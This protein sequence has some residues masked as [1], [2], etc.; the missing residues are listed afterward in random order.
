M[1]S[2]E[3]R[4]R[5]VTIGASQTM[6]A[7]F[8]FLTA[9]V[10]TVVLVPLVGQFAR[11][12]G[13]TSQPSSNR[14]GRRSV[15][16]IGGVAMV[17]PLLFAA[18]LGGGFVA[19]RPVLIAS[20]L[21]FG[22]GLVDDLRAFRPATKLVLQMIVAAVLLA[23][24]PSI[25]ITG[26]VW[27]DLLL[28]FAWIVGITN[29]V[30]LLDNMDGLASGVA[31]IAAVSLL[32]VLYLD[33]TAATEPLSIGMAAFVGAT[34]GFLL[35]NFH[36]ASI[37]MGDGGSHLLGCFLAGS[38]LMATPAMASHVA[39]VAAIP[40]VLLLIPIFDTGFVTLARGLSG[41]SAFLGG[42]DHTSHRLAALGMGE[43]RAVVVLY[44]LALTG[45]AV[46]VG[47]IGLPP[48]LAYGLVALYVA[49]LGLIGV[50][51]GHVG[52]T[53]DVVSDPAPL[54]S[55]ITSKYRIYEVLLDTV[56][57]MGAY[58]LAFI[59]RFREAEFDAFVGYFVQSVPIVVGIQIATL[60][61]SGKYRQA[62]GHFG[63]REIFALGW[64]AVLGVAASVIAMLYIYRFEGYSR[65]VFAFDAVLAPA[66]I[67]TARVTVSAIDDYLRLRRTRGRAA[68]IYGAGRSGALAV[69]ELLQ[70]A[71]LGLTP[72][73]Y[74]DDNPA[75]R[76]QR[77]DG[78]PV[79]G[80]LED[81]PGILDR[82][83]GQV[84]TLVIG[85]TEL[86]RDKLE[87]AAE[88]CAAR[89]IAV[90]RVRF[91]LEEVRRQPP[92][93]VVRFPGT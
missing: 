10:F 40:V 61:V 85:I 89:G 22:V 13:F 45:G 75:K 36:P 53:R 82:R 63:P 58:Y 79:L 2:A 64:T 19:L 41:K 14:W 35:F 3:S 29:A 42:R 33:G 70:N 90:R 48:A 57:V 43:R 54:P 4:R 77:F 26:V 71:A 50:Y 5:G 80:S 7:F 17:G 32:L 38:A 51:L 78:L 11:A 87:R 86:S 49:G 52:V 91:D 72:V 73:A 28:G 23:L 47:L 88:I 76:K 65:W 93:A 31:V 46:G 92:G 66:F 8:A 59:G 55:E 15:P 37:F 69:R 18:T 25:H 83:P 60:W 68:L 21:M 34:L 6:P 67:V 81:L 44:V 12:R 62:W 39:P 1:T 20:T 56:L 74:L 84:S 30:N 16:N 24:L 27:L 9:F